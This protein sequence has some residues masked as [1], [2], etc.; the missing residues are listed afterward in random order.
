MKLY[1]I[2]IIS[3]MS[4]N[5][6]CNASTVLFK[7][8]SEHVINIISYTKGRFKY[9]KSNGSVSSISAKKINTVY[10]DK[11]SI[12]KKSKKSIKNDDKPVIQM[13]DIG[14]YSLWK[15]FT[16]L[17][18]SAK[19]KKL[20]GRKISLRI[21]LT[22]EPS[23]SHIFGY[24]F[25]GKVLY[26]IS[27]RYKDSSKSLHNKKV[28]STVSLTGIISGVNFSGYDNYIEPQLYLINKTKHKYKYKTIKTKYVFNISLQNANIKN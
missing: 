21:T 22:G 28:G 1:I 18:R 6:Y 27:A 11:N 25:N 16:N 2:C 17:Q 20:K 7:N 10:F 23:K 9:K 4:V 3:F 19:H 14:S 8:G 26:Y 12:H 13:R 5:I 15:N 24:I